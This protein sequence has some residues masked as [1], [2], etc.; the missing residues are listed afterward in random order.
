VAGDT[1]VGVSVGNG[2]GTDVS[3][4]LVGVTRG[5]G[6]FVGCSFGGFFVGD[7]STS[8]LATVLDSRAC[9]SAVWG[10]RQATSS[11]SAGSSSKGMSL[12]FMDVHHIIPDWG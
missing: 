3:G 5:V 7:G 10:S 9:V 8:I 12:S 11:M 4:A 2:I 1:G 6:C